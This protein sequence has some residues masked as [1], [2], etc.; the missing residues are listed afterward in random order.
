MPRLIAILAFVFIEATYLV[1]MNNLEAGVLPAIFGGV[2]A[3]AASVY[4]GDRWID[5]QNNPPVV[6]VAM[7]PAKAY[8]VIKKALRRTRVGQRRWVIADH[9]PR[10][11][12]IYAVAEWIDPPFEILSLGMREPLFRQVV[13]EVDIYRDRETRTTS[14]ELRWAMDADLTKLGCIQL[15]R[16]TTAEILAA[17]HEASI[18]PAIA[19]GAV[20]QEEE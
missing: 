11:Y 6:S 19:A 10:A 2:I 3:F 5:K 16:I 9:D 12:N 1:S 15:Q 18:H 20:F 14:V 4:F 13:L 17:L 7:P 8:A